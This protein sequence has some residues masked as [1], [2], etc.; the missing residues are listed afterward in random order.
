MV[1]TSDIWPKYVSDPKE[2]IKEVYE[3][4]NGNQDSGEQLVSADRVYSAIEENFRN[5]LLKPSVL[6]E[7][8]SLNCVANLS[9]LREGSLVRFRCMVQDPSFG[10]ELGLISAKARNKRTGEIKVLINVYSDNHSDLGPEEWDILPT[11]PSSSQF[12]EREIMYCI[13]IPGESEWVTK[14]DKVVDATETTEREGVVPN[15]PEK[16]PLGLQ[17]HAGAIVKFIKSENL[18]KVSQAFDIVGIFE[19]GLNPHSEDQLLPYVDYLRSACLSYLSGLVGGDE[20][21]GLL[22]V[23]NLLSATMSVKDTKVGSL[24]LNIS[25]FPTV[26]DS[27]P[28]EEG[29]LRN[30]AATN[31]TS[32]LEK[33]VPWCVQLPLSISSLNKLKYQ[34]NAESSHIKAGVLQL[35]P[36]TLIVCDETELEEGTLQENGVR[37]LQAL[38][39]MATDQCLTYQFPFQPIDIDTNTRIVVLSS[40]KSL[41]KLDVS[42]PLEKA[43]HDTIIKNCTYGQ[44]SKDSLSDEQLWSLRSYLLNCQKL[45]Y[46]I[47]KDISEASSYYAESR[48]QAQGS[49]TNM[50][51]QESLSF[52]LT[53]A[54]LISISKYQ[55]QLSLE[56]WQEAK[57]LY[58]KIKERKE[59][60]RQSVSEDN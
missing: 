47:P 15:I 42:I 44:H 30:L 16:H 50:P 35:A 52:M 12:S 7:I 31:L 46:E 43:A 9:H 37:N 21:V 49:E 57:A 34:P 23:L 28:K 6:K 58:Q 20:A 41:L 22:L 14:N 24:G 48:R 40:G 19:W 45:S 60:N 10:D 33:F 39:R 51:T 2:I 38:Q 29:K 36:S 27:G 11:D 25:N 26:P 3:Q 55:Q 13:G 17:K 1:A 18:P 4:V 8:P 54:R 5:T 32:S 59:L 56:S 53:L